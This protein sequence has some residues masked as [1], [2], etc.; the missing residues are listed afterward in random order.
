MR[1]FSATQSLTLFSFSLSLFLSLS[2]SPSALQF[3]RNS[4]YLD[5]YEQKRL[6]LGSNNL[7]KVTACS[8]GKPGS[9]TPWLSEEGSKEIVVNMDP[10]L[11]SRN[12]Q[13][14]FELKRVYQ[15]AP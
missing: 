14:T 15:Q 1:V 10:D 8:A 3:P 7:A 9:F 6:G 13:G 5:N 4:F 11:Y 2:I 12:R